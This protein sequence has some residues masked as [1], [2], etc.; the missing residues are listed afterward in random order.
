MEKLTTEIRTAFASFDDLT[1]EALAHQKYLMAVLQ[2]G[3]RMYPPVPTTLPR[4]VP[5][6]GMAVHG[7][8][9]P[10]GTVVGVNHMGVYR[11]KAHFKYPNEFHPERWL[12]DPE[13]SDDHLDALEVFS[14][15]PRN[16]LGKNLA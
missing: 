5:K 9:V 10:E 3:M 4:V 8:W 11:S 7:Q 15:G 16:C 6:G 1:L 2:E 14:T 13:F 12:G